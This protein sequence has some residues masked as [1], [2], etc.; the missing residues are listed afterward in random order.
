MGPEAKRDYGPHMFTWHQVWTEFL[1]V[2]RF[3]CSCKDYLPLLTTIANFEQ[4]WK[5]RFW[6]GIAFFR[7]F[8][9]LFN[10]KSY[11]LENRRTFS[12]LLEVFNPGKNSQYILNSSDGFSPC[13]KVLDLHAVEFTLLSFFCSL[14]SS[15][16]N[17]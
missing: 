12:Q 5:N 11:R 14:N 9:G 17:I 15:R 3:R 4:A 6:G 2:A 8:P 1:K 16:F 10:L 13:R 7:Y